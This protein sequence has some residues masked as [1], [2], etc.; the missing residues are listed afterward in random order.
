MSHSFL[1]SQSRKD[2][3]WNRFGS[4]HQNQQPLGAA[5]V[6]TPRGRRLLRL[7]A[8]TAERSS[9]RRLGPVEASVGS[10]A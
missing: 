3:H 6:Y 8:W 4:P 2:D 5:H 9:R 1:P 10:W 7:V